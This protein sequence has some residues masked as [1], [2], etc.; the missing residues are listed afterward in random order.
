MP[1][2][3]K[4]YDLVIHTEFKKDLQKNPLAPG[5]SPS[6][7]L[8][9]LEDHTAIHPHEKYHIPITR[10]S[11]LPLSKS[12]QARKAKASYPNQQRSV[13]A[14]SSPQSTSSEYQEDTP[15]NA[16]SLRIQEVQVQPVTN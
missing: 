2:R 7:D 6:R 12:Y 1:H 13:T 8:F 4:T 15:P 10:K 9:T 3:R 11:T 14:E 5:S 16:S